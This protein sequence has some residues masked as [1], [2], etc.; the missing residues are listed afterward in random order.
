MNQQERRTKTRYPNML[1]WGST[2][3]PGA[4]PKEWEKNDSEYM[5]IE[6]EKAEQQVWIRIAVWLVLG[7]CAFVVYDSIRGYL[8]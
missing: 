6:R 8:P 5:R 4:V 2:E 3:K 7:Y 1:P